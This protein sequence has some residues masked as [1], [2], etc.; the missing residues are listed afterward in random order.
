MVVKHWLESRM[1]RMKYFTMCTE[2]TDQCRTLI[3]LPTGNKSTPVFLTRNAKGRRR[4]VTSIGKSPMSS[5]KIKPCSTCNELLHFFTSRI[6]FVSISVHHC[7]LNFKYELKKAFTYV[8]CIW[9]KVR[10]NLINAFP[11]TKFDAV[12]VH[13]AKISY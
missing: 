10:Y 4:N 7:L 12:T 13:I 11:K 1:E 8:I 2:F 6:S 9:N 3:Y 5:G